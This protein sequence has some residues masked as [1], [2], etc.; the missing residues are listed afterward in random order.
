[1]PSSIYSGVYN[2]NGEIDIVRRLKAGHPELDP[3]A[4]KK[5]RAQGKK[6][7]EA[8]SSSEEMASASKEASSILKETSSSSVETSRASKKLTSAST[9]TENSFG[10]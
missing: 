9:E 6:Q 4:R 10:V 2:M 8:S 1:M 7:S 5:L 3:V